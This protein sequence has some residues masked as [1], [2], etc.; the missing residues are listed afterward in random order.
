MNKKLCSDV[1]P[2]VIPV[3]LC[4]FL[5]KKKKDLKSIGL[6]HVLFLQATK[7]QP[8]AECIKHVLFFLS[9]KL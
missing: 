5:I 2:N 6:I 1:Q 3:R 7:V 4:T 9:M 8:V